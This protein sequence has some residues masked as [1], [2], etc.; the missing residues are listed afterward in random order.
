MCRIRWISSA[1]RFASHS[2]Y[3]SL[4]AVD[5]W[6]LWSLEN[7]PQRPALEAN[8]LVARTVKCHI[9][10]A[11]IGGMRTVRSSEMADPYVERPA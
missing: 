11:T 6:R 1:N 3:S 5:D 7:L 2:P 4:F 10:N 8:S 9:E